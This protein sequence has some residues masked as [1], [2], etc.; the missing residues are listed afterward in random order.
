MKKTAACCLALSLYVFAVGSTSV[1]PRLPGFV[2]LSS[3]PDADELSLAVLADASPLPTAPLPTPRNVLADSVTIRNVE[4]SPSDPVREALP[5]VA[6]LPPAGESSLAPALAPETRPVALPTVTP[7]PQPVMVA[8]AS[9]LP[10]TSPAVDTVNSVA[11][12][13]WVTGPPASLGL[14]PF[15]VKYCSASGIPVVAS[16][17]VPD[18]ALQRAWEIVSQMLD[19]MPRAEAVRNSLTRTSTRIGIIGAAQVTT[20]M[21]E[22]RA[23]YTL[24]PDVDWNSR[25]RGVGATLEI[26][27]LSIAEENLLCYPGDRWTGQNVLVHEF[28]HTIKNMGLDLVDPTFR[29]EVQR[30]YEQALAAGLWPGTYVSSDMEEYWAEGV[31]L[32]FQIDAAGAPGG[33]PYP[34]NSR[35][36]LQRYDPTLYRLVEQVFGPHAGISP[37][38][39]E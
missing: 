5:E 39:S 23:L 29:A 38:P 37:C 31:R 19:G 12:D 24:F 7:T 27:L 11:N 3:Q 13:C 21:P 14:D 30:T 9:P 4:V 17:E 15:Y 8:D 26:P 35:A 34:A 6:V 25:A 1:W 32:Y 28:A 2:T 10:A 20:D 18:R 22:H 33:Q 36:E 16:A